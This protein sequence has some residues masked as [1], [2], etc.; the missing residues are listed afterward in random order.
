MF[1]FTKFPSPPHF[2]NFTAG[3]GALAPIKLGCLFT[4]FPDSLARSPRPPSSP[5]PRKRTSSI[6]TL[7]DAELRSGS[8][9][10]ASKLI[11]DLRIFEKEADLEKK[12]AGRISMGSEVDG[13]AG[14]QSE[15]RRIWNGRAVGREKGSSWWAESGPG[16]GLERVLAGPEGRVLEVEVL[17]EGL[18]L[19]LDFPE[20]RRDECGGGGG[21]GGGDGVAR[22]GGVAET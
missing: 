5:S 10:E 2:R 11:E 7:L 21:G 6:S 22:R 14:T 20:T 3:I 13:G 1:N 12:P 19:I 18:I 8:F 17:E 16:S 9:P 15:V 4:D